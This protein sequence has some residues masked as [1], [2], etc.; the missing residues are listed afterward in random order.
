MGDQGAKRGTGRRRH[1]RARGCGRPSRT[2]GRPMNEDVVALE[3]SGLGKRYGRK[4]GLED[5]S[6]HLPTGR[7]AALVGP[8]GSG[9]STLLRMAAGITRPTAGEV[10]VFGHSPQ[11]PTVDVLRQIGYLD[12]ER[13]LYRSFRVGE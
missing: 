10:R 9:K 5:C 6:F 7:I 4:W 3:T 8:N 12:Q 2:A 13:P 11:E 1:R